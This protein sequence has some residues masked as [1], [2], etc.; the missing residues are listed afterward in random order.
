MFS[1]LT[2]TTSERNQS[3]FSDVVIV[4]CKQISHIFLEFLLLTLDKYMSAE[5]LSGAATQL[6]HQFDCSKNIT[7]FPKTE[8]H[9]LK[10]H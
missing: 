9:S 2:I 7:M 3:L 4:N 5:L 6:F 8:S 1:K 10:H